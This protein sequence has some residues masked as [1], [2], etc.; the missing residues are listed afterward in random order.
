MVNVMKFLVDLDDTICDANGFSEMFIK[1]FI[2]KYK[3]PYKQITKPARFAE[4]KFDWSEDVAIQWYKKYGDK[5]MLEFVCKD[6]VKE[7]L[8]QLK[9][10]NHEIIIVTARNTDWHTDPKGSH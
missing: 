2:K 9:E 7:T 10:L 8:N 4:M 3:L 6:K 5:M 1:N